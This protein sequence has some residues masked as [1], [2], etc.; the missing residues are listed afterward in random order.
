[1]YKEYFG[2]KENPFSI[3]PDPHYFF[4]SEGHREALA[5][6]VYGI[7]A[8]GGFILLTG[9]VG[10]GKTTV[11]RRLLAQMPDHADIAFILNPKVTVEELLASICDE[12]GIKYPEGNRSNKVF[13]SAIN[14]YLI[15]THAKG[16]RAILIIEE[17]QNLSTDVLEQIRLLTNLE[18]NQYKL[19]QIILLGQPELRDIL[20]K[21][22]LRQLSQRITARYHLGPLS[23]EEMT[24]YIDHRLSTAG[25]AR[26][27]LFTRDALRLLF[28]L[29]NGIPRLIN[30]ICDR[31]FIGAFVQGE[32]KVDR[33]T[34]LTAA[35]EVTGKEK[36][37]RSRFRLYTAISF[38]VLLLLFSAALIAHFLQNPFLLHKQN[39]AYGSPSMTYEEVNQMIGPG[40][41]GVAVPGRQPQ[42][43]DMPAGTSAIQLKEAAWQ[44]LFGTW[45]EGYDPK[46]RADACEQARVHGL[47][48]L[49]GKDSLPD[50]KQM[51]KPAV[52][53]LTNDEG[54]EYYAMLTSM[55]DKE[56][57][58][59]IGSEKRV[60]GIDEIVKRWTGEYTLL[61]MPPE[62]YKGAVKPGGK[63]PFADWLREKLDQAG[64]DIQGPGYGKNITKD[65]A[66]FQ[67]SVG[68]KP[69][70]IAGARTI[71]SLAN[72]VG[73]NGPALNKEG[74]K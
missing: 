36:V 49:E 4:M 11:C 22:E 21:P 69:D 50:L 29:T 42:T 35:H 14:S 28:R 41:N 39:R 64:K 43:L 7:D 10:T 62:G 55:N 65:L 25:Y 16:R 32:E 58:F 45:Q 5:H 37:S 2:L 13:V 47:Q 8:E 66:Q 24:A 40:E 34:V 46:G 53:K 57:T 30:I 15:D 56:A 20:A 59:A 9:E 31:A 6:L 70:G 61:W 26:G 72:A 63:G 17:A 38:A 52:L 27:H 54:I 33:K 3:A 67:I 71:I 51:N 18:T 44:A 60:V 19:L 68:L 12:F 73:S 48:C 1:M 74:G 23:R